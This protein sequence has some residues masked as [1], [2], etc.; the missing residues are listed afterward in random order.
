[1]CTSN[2]DVRGDRRG[3]R[4]SRMALDEAGE[5]SLP[6]CPRPRCTEANGSTTRQTGG[7][8][9]RQSATRCRDLQTHGDRLERD[10]I[11]RH[12]RGPGD[13]ADT[14]RRLTSAAGTRLTSAV[15]AIDALARATEVKAADVELLGSQV[16]GTSRY[17]TRTSS[18]SN[19]VRRRRTVPEGVLA[20]GGVD[21]G[22][23]TATADADSRPRRVRQTDRLSR[24]GLGGRQSRRRVR[25]RPAP[26]RSS[27][28]TW[29]VR[30]LEIVRAT[31]LDRHPCP[32]RRSARRHRST[33]RPRG[34]GPSVA[35]SQLERRRK[36]VSRSAGVRR[37]RRTQA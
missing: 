33:R 32:S 12:R 24:H 34:A 31:W 26:Q 19:F 11:D 22:G 21:S 29:D 23:L 30:R 9:P 8:D 17:R 4:E 28:Y 25:R 10:E 13:Y 14:G 16:S 2:R 18:R 35:T 6:E 20:A 7:I 15:A 5:E 36:R 37:E 3:A 27:Q 1:M